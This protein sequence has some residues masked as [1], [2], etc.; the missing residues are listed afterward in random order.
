[1]AACFAR[2][3]RI[4]NQEER[5]RARD[6]HI[7]EIHKIMVHLEEVNKT[8]LRDLVKVEADIGKVK[9]ENIPLKQLMSDVSN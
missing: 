6:K 4:A 2:V 1:M 8:R 7:Q 9:E 3:Q 5:I